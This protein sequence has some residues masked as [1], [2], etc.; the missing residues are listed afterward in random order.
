MP[1]NQISNDLGV[2]FID[3]R[4][5]TAGSPPDDE[6]SITT[7]A[8]YASIDNLDARLTAI[9]AALYTQAVLDKMTVNDKVYAVRLNDDA[10]SL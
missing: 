5:A 10:G 9:N 8:N 6:T 2:A 4:R 1:Q 7:P 3:K